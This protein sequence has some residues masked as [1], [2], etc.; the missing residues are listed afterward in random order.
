M[1]RGEANCLRQEAILYMIRIRGYVM[2]EYEKRVLSPGT[3]ENQS[4]FCHSSRSSA[5]R[6][7][8]PGAVGMIQVH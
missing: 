6:L 4:C 2:Y 5:F 1:L 3:C 7:K 8:H